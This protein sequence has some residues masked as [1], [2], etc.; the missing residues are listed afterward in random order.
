MDFENHKIL[1]KDSS[2]GCSSRIY[3][4]RSSE[5]VPFQWEMQPGIAKAE[6]APKTELLLPPLSPPPA[7]LS[8][9]LP[10]PSFFEDPKPSSST[11][12][13]RLRFWQRKREINRNNSRKLKQGTQECSRDSSVEFVDC[14]CYSDEES[15]TMMASPAGSSFS[16]SGSSSF[17]FRKSR[18]SFVSARSESPSRSEIYGKTLSCFPVIPV[19]ILVSI[20]RRD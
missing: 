15:V 19:Q 1:R 18:S 13:K 5:G 16:S 8:L 6:H 12:S 2:V 11:W 17:S 10:K 3:Y 9:G 20:V 4:P 14:A 7:I